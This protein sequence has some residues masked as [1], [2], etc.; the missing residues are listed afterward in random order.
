MSP[1]ISVECPVCHY[2]FEVDL[3]EQPPEKTVYRGEGAQR[4][5]VSEYRF[6]CPRDGVYFIVPVTLQE[7]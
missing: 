3:A 1:K 5:A 4:E 2:S 7:D 6:Q